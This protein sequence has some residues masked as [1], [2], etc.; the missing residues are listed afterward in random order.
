MYVC[1]N[2][3]EIESELTYLFQFLICMALVTVYT[4]DESLRMQLVAERAP[5]PLGPCPSNRCMMSRT[6]QLSHG[7][8]SLSWK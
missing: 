7:S 3:N 5:G 8:S 2:I 4:Y 6:H 1:M